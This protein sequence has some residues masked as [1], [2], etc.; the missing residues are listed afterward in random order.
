M[1]KMKMRGRTGM[2]IFNT[3]GGRVDSFDAL[4]D[5]MKAEIRANYPDYDAPPPLDD[6]RPNV[7]S[8]SYFKEVI[9]ARRAEG[10]QGGAQ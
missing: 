9:D 7:T 2:M 5:R 8:W 6:D 10:G 1:R 4:P 3:V